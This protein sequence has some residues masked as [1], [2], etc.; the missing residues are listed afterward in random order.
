MNKLM[1]KKYKKSLNIEK[2]GFIKS[3]KTDKKSFS[4]LLDKN[5]NSQN[6][7]HYKDHLFRIDKINFRSAISLNYSNLSRLMNNNERSNKLRSYIIDKATPSFEKL[8]PKQIILKNKSIFRT[9][10]Q[11]QQSSILKVI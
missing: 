2:K 7:K 3:I 11:S 6:C 10:N 1:L 5:L 8:L 9:L 4:L